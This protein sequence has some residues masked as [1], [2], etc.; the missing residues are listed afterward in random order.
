MVRNASINSAINRGLRKSQG[1]GFREKNVGF[2][3]NKKEDYPAQGFS[4]EK[5]LGYQ[6]TYDDAG[7]FDGRSRDRATSDRGFQPGGKPFRHRTHDRTDKRILRRPKY[8]RQAKMGVTPGVKQ[9]YDFKHKG[10]I[11]FDKSYQSPDRETLHHDNNTYGAGNERP[12]SFDRTPYQPRESGGSPYNHESRK[13]RYGG[14]SSGDYRKPSLS[15]SSPGTFED[16]SDSTNRPG[17]RNDSR[18]PLAIPYTTPASEF[19]Y[20]TS[21]V[22]AALH[23]RAWRCRKLYKLYVQTGENRVH[24]Q[25]DS[26]ITKDALLKG[27][28]VERVSGPE[29]TQILDKMS[30]GRPHNGYILEA[31]PL[32]RLPVVSLAEVV[33]EEDHMLIEVYKHSPGRNPLVIFI[34]SILDPQNLGAI[35]RT[36]SFMGAAAIAQSVRNT[37]S[38]T[39]TALKAS[40]GASEN[41]PILH[42]NKPGEFIARSKSAGW[43]VYAAVAPEDL[44]QTEPWPK[45]QKA[46][47]SK[48]KDPDVEP[49]SIKSVYTDDL[50][51]P[52]SGHPCILMLGG[53]GEGL[54]RGLRNQADVEISIKNRGQGSKLDSLNVSVATGILCDAFMRPTAKKSAE[55]AV[56]AVEEEMK[57][58]D[59]NRL[60]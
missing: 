8:E 56:R 18:I 37:A 31:S 53:E 1:V 45:T 3:R 25:R 14:E 9:S 44:R 28:P 42:V 47:S 19:L 52:L 55:E 4:S 10:R 17:Y 59:Q 48:K 43:K 7:R 16:R 51:D 22:E 24:A 26:Q 20:G 13:T 57:E 12:S 30:N 23:A 60:F 41:I 32:P 27:I 6:K 46:D 35:V 34:D 40:A 54:R 33:E 58:L 50:N 15:S 29:W 39:P 38:F 5:R 49:R 11:P 36:A 21:V 2:S